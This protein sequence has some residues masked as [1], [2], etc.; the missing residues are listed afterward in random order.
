MSSHR[1]TPELAGTVILAIIAAGA[2]VAGKIP[3]L[4]LM[5][6]LGVVAAG[7][8]FRLARSRGAH[9]LSFVGLVSIISLFVAA[10]LKGERAPAAFG[11][12]VAAAAGFAFLMAIVRRS[13]AG[14]TEGLMSTLVPV[15]VVG[16]LGGYILAIRGIPHGLRLVL[17]FGAIALLADIAIELAGTRAQIPRARTG[18][19]LAGAIAGGVLCA[20]VLHRAFTWGTAMIVA[21]LIGLVVAGTDPIASMLERALSGRQKP[22]LMLR[23]IDGVLLSAP[24]FFYAYRAL[25]R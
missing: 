2:A 9:P 22:A 6:V 10:E 12:V 16:L 8:Q 15:L 17:G 14:V 18:V 13:R 7:E 1:E 24:V 4:I 19:A 11:A 3:L 20:T 25:A 23:R 5:V 21:V